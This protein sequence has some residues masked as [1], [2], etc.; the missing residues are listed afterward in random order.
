MNN[1]TSLWV[2]LSA[3]ALSAFISFKLMVLEHQAA[4][5]KQYIEIQ[6][7]AHDVQNNSIEFLRGH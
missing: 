2:A 5:A 1:N 4:H 6:L 7:T 3:L